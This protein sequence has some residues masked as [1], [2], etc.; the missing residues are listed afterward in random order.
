MVIDSRRIMSFLL[1]LCRRATPRKPPA[2]DEHA[3][4]FGEFLR[5]Q[6]VL[7]LTYAAIAA[8]TSAVFGLDYLAIT[9]AA[10]SVLMAIPFFGRSLA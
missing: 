10:A 9:S 8:L 2:G 4:S 5:S 6:A 3:H 1:R 7:G